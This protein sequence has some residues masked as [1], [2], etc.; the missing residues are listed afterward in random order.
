MKQLMTDLLG[1]LLP[2]ERRNFYILVCITTVS[3]LFEATSVASILPLLTVLADPGLIE[4][5]D[6]LAAAYRFS[7]V[8]SAQQFQLYLAVIAFVMVVFGL[9]LKTATAYAITRYS[10]MREYSISSR[11]LQ[12]YL[13]QPYEWYL[14]HHTAKLSRSILADVGGLVGQTLLPLL[15]L[16]ASAT[17]VLF[18]VLMLFLAEPLVATVVACVLSV[19]YLGIYMSI[20]NY[21]ALLGKRRLEAN[22]ERFR[23]TQEALEGIK[24]VKLRS[25]ED[26][27]VGRFS[28]PARLMARI[29]ARTQ[30][31]R[32]VPRHILEIIAFGGMLAFI[33]FNLVGENRGLAQMI[34]T[35]GLVAFA[36]M[37]LLPALQIVFS[38]LA[39]LRASMPIVKSIAD[40]LRDVERRNPE[41]RDPAPSPL[42]LKADLRIEGLEY[43]YP[44][45]EQAALS[46]LDM[47][48]PAHTTVGIVGGTGAGKTTA[49]DLMLGLLDPTGGRIVVDGVEITAKNRR[50]W[51]R[52]LGYVPQTIFLTADSV[53]ANIAFGVAPDEIDMDRITA[54]AKAA[55]LHDFILSDL[56]EGYDTPLGE[57]G[58]RLSGGQRQRIG[59]ARAL[60]FDPEVLI[61]DEA[62]SAL[63]NIT[64][65]EV[66]AAI[67]NLSGEKTIIMIA[68]RLTTV[69]NCDQIFL[70]EHGRVS[71]SGA[72]DELARQS[73]TFREMARNV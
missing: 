9:L 13:H 63:D 37:R 51:Q 73:D 11:I 64:E 39:S 1:I 55:A 15:K 65:R 17:L 32:D 59:I 34:P 70:L 20:R 40:A 28:I 21:L 66:M 29:N 5:N 46:G 6:Y 47:H 8:E 71:A 2:R 50:N 43:G 4:S 18:L 3:A 26:I 44:N 10:A 48:I 42:P 24:Y 31:L 58:V 54:A 68:H 35:L 36:G 49:I 27:Y 62:T 33:M 60:Y 45:A 61:F 53:A 69:K 56:P 12:G 30:V 22:A 16:I 72:F 57:R 19:A 25:I 52:S 7:Q 38:M 23:V 41:G 14:T 67:D